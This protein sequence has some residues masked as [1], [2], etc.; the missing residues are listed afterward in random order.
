MKAEIKQTEITLR[1]QN[2]REL[3]KQTVITISE[4]VR[5]FCIAESF[6]RRRI[7]GEEN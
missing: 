4:N 2:S 5:R 6:L 7:K 1:G 3:K